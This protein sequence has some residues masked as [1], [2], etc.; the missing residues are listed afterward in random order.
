MG[1]EQ[2]GFSVGKLP[3]HNSRE[4]CRKHLQRLISR[5]GVI[6]SDFTGPTNF[7]PADIA[8]IIIR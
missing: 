3:A 4:Y 5:L 8:V 6:I 7:Y 2:F 1:E